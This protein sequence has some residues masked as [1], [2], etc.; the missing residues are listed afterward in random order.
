MEKTLKMS[1]KGIRA[2]LAEARQPDIFDYLAWRAD[3]PFSVD[4]FNE[5]DNLIL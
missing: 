4:P 5:V 3:V 1:G 2:V